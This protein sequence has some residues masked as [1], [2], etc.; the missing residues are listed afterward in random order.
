MTTPTRM[1]RGLSSTFQLQH[2]GLWLGAMLLALTVLA[3]LSP[4][5]LAQAVRPPSNAVNQESTG[6]PVQTI[7]QKGGNY[8]I[9]LWKKLREGV[10]GTVSVPDHASGILVQAEGTEWTETKRNELPEW[11]GYALAGML[12]FLALF[13]LVRGTVRIE[14]GPA[15]QTITRFSGVERMAHWLMAVSFLL[16]GATGLVALYGRDLLIPV[17]GKAA[18]AS[19]AAGSKWIHAYVAF[20]FMVGLALSFL[21]WVRHNFPNRYDFIWLAKAGGLFSKHSHPPAKKF[22]AGQKILFWLIMIGGVSLS[23]SGLS[24]LLPFEFPLFDKTFTLLN[25]FGLHLPTGLTA[26]E[27]MQYAVTWHSIVALGLLC[28]ILAHIYIG[29][30]GMEGAFDAMGSGEVD[31]NWAKE[32]HSV[33]AAE[34]TQKE[35]DARP[36]SDERLQPA[37]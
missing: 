36:G 34:E 14:H 8:D 22:N 16:Q 5:A 6:A 1:S 10:P 32:H 27:E 7:P 17:M 33:W 28:V 30:I 3:S 4:T 31:V 25:S 2:A 23:L 12:A 35:R 26:V 24:L 20:A 37:E 11:G 9:E 13:Y 29:T 19:F 15:G 21:L 18:F